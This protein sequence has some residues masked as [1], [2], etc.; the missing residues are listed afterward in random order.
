MGF[1]LQICWL[2]HATK[3][4]DD[5]LSLCF[6]N[7][8]RTALWRST[9]LQT[10]PWNPVH[11]PSY[12]KLKGFDLSMVVP[13]LLHVWNLG[14]S[15]DVIGSTLR[16]I[17]SDQVVF[18]GPTLPD[19]L[20]LATESLTQFARRR[21]LP[22]RLKKITKNKLSWDSKKYPSFASS[23][24]DAYVVGLWL[25][26]ILTPHERTFPEFFRWF[27]QATRSFHSCMKQGVF[28]LR[29]KKQQLRSL[30]TFLRVDFCHWPM[31]RCGE[32]QSCGGS[33]P[34]SICY[35][36]FFFTGAHQPVSLQYVDG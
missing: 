1:S 29:K 13:D 19:R 35:V 10:V 30:V 24:Y 2:C 6:T 15:R 3:G 34:N 33:N 5:D 22:L 18:G 14:V 32:M 9:Y 36:T 28:F 12:V 25:E 21:S 17:L 8:S 23:G 31:Q 26:N 20:H 16:V 11:E 4:S 27:G 7:V